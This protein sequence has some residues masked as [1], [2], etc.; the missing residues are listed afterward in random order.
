MKREKIIIS[1]VLALG[2]TICIGYGYGTYKLNTMVRKVESPIVKDN[3]SLKVKLNKIGELDK[4]GQAL[5]FTI[6]TEDSTLTFGKINI[7]LYAEDS[8]N[9]YKLPTKIEKEKREEILSMLSASP[10]SYRAVST[11]PNSL[12][13]RKLYAVV[14]LD[15]VDYKVD[16]D[17]ATM[18][19]VE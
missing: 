9:T 6:C 17:L 18:E 5:D 14:T 13:D 10:W 15:D 8:N 3:P 11:I 2:V 4:G 1:L 7:V 12:K 19:V 16:V